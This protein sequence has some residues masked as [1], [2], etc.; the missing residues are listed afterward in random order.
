MSVRD[1]ISKVSKVTKVRPA[2]GRV[3]RVRFA[4]DRRERELDLTGLIAR[5]K[6]FMPL[7]DDAETFGKVRIVEG[8][9]G[10]AWPVQTKWGRLDLSASTLRRIA[11]E[12]QPMTG[13]DFAKWRRSLGLSL[14]EAAKL[15]GVG[16]RTIT[17]YLKKDELPLVVAIAHLSD[18]TVR[19][20]AG[21]QI[22][23]AVL[24]RKAGAGTVLPSWL[25]AG[26]GR[27]T[28]YRVA[29]AASRDVAWEIC[30]TG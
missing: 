8:G 30:L 25:V 9:L 16:R 2:N 15:L 24:M 12:Q 17:G 22:A 27:A 26:F 10:V 19:V 6:H 18:P 29:G 7:L 23:S 13:A 1:E 3:L 14:T 5:S 28:H 4:G 20:Q 11:E 21:Q